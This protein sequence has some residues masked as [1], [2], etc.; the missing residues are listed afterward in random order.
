MIDSILINIIVWVIL[1]YIG[2]VVGDIALLLELKK[3]VR[4]G[5]KCEQA[6]HEWIQIQ[7]HEAILFPCLGF[8]IAFVLFLCF[9]H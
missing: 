4:K 1:L 8:C 7:M 5:L 9:L 2:I 3:E 6:M